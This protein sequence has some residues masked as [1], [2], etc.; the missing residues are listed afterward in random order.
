MDDLEQSTTGR[1]R[2]LWL[3]G[4]GAVATLSGCLGGSGNGNGSDDEEGDGSGDDA[5][6]TDDEPGDDEFWEYDASSADRVEIPA[7]ATCVVCPMPPA[8]YP[9]WNAQAAHEDGT[10][11]F[12]CSPGCAVAY[13]AYPDVFDAPPALANWWVTDAATGAAVDGREATYV[14]DSNPDR[15]H[16]PMVNPYP[17]ADREDALEYVASH[18]DLAEDD[19]VPGTDLGAD[20]ATTFREP[21]IERARE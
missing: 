15:A 5:A 8:E 1:R 14:L 3:A 13:T 16:G 4:T 17:F 12:F 19:V 21:Y 9:D 11:A 6:G 7:E 20:V 18:D 10:R 2:L